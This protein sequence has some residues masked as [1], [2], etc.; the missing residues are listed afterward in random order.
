MSLNRLIY[1]SAII[2]GWSAF[3]GWMIS[4][5]LLNR[6]GGSGGRLAVAMTCALVGGAIG[7][8]LNLVAGMANA[9]WKQQIKRVLPGFI[10]GGLGGAIGGFMGDILFSVFHVRALG[11]MIMGAGIGV[12]EGLYE[13]SPAKLRNG[14]IGG[15][16]GGLIGGFLFD[17]IRNLIGSSSNMSSRATA[18]VIL[19]MC[20]GILIGLV[21][22]VFKEAWLT[23]LD[24]YRPGRQLILSDA[25]S[26]LGCAEYA[27]LPFVGRG[28][29]EVAQVH[30]R[31]IRQPDGRFALEDNQTAH[32]TRVNNVRVNGQVLLNDG[33]VIRL[34]RNSIRF[35]ERHHRGGEAEPAAAPVS[36]WEEEAPAPA[37]ARPPLPSVAPAPA[38]PPLPVA[39]PVTRPIDG[40]GSRPPIPAAARSARTREAAAPAGRHPGPRVP[41]APPPRAASPV[42]APP[43]RPAA[44]AAPALPGPR[45][46]VPRPSHRPPPRNRRSPPHPGRRRPLRTGR[47]SV[48]AAGKRCPRGRIT[49]SSATSI[50]EGLFPKVV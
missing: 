7:T 46:W 15:A 38:R 4:E 13:R 10:A 8:G 31:V 49:A 25:E 43:P 9:Q 3:L 22:V 34:G 44:P 36:V 23:V 42:A 24:G 39:A 18:F 11:W 47:P 6:G 29:N 26:V 32:G 35:S 17:P 2:G 41:P 28:D 33:D 20:I 16:I 19:G 27:S 5:F 37:P 12:V 1:Y 48:R 21:K 50:S 30:A 45:P 40:P 14:L